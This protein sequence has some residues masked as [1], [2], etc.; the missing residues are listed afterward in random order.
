[1]RSMLVLLASF[2][3]ALALFLCGA[4]VCGASTYYADG[5]TEDGYVYRG[6]YWWAAGDPYT[7]TRIDYT[8]PYYYCGRVYYR[9]YYYYKYTRV[10]PD[11][12]TVKSTDPDYRSKLLEIAKQ[13]DKIEGDIRK[14]AAQHNE[15]VEAVQAL[16]FTSNFT[17]QSY[18]VSPT[19]AS[20]LRYQ[21]GNFGVNA[22][23][24]YGVSQYAEAYNPYDPNIDAQQSA[25]LAKGAQAYAESAQGGFNT[26]ANIFATGIQRAAEIEAAGRASERA[27]I[28]ARAAPQTRTT[29]TV[30]TPN[31]SD[32]P[33]VMPKVSVG[34]KVAPFAAANECM[35]C[36]SGSN[37][38]GKFDVTAWKTLTEDQKFS[39]VSNHLL[40]K[41]LTKRMPRKEDGSVGNRLSARKIKEFLE[42]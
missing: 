39:I 33:D 25:A 9:P 36:H 1:M 20:P 38:N 3:C 37:V 42:N 13:R 14:S 8:E 5:Y 31:A 40:T 27:L 11:V 16:G 32:V 18:G 34:A 21:V 19:Y 2:L 35:A 6:G 29:T 41:D 30:I 15:F 22:S 12:S 10:Y 24:I 26:R 28:A 17:W 4:S 23:T 7:R